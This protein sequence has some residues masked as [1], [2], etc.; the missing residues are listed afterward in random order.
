MFF[1]YYV[2][3]NIIFIFTPVF[4]IDISELLLIA[5]FYTFSTYLNNQDTFVPTSDYSF[6]FRHVS[7]HACMLVGRDV[8]NS[9]YLQGT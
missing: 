6:R 3:G 1:Y 5:L 9:L 4:L 8:G 2:V 7:V